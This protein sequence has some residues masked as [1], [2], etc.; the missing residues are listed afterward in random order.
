MLLK[1]LLFGVSLLAGS[2]TQARERTLSLVGVYSQS[3][4]TF[5][6]D[7]NSPY[8]YGEDSLA[9]ASINYG[10]L[11]ETPMQGKWGFETGLIFLQRGYQFPVSPGASTKNVSSWK[12]FYV[13]LVGRF[14]PTSVFTGSIGMYLDQAVGELGTYSTA[15]PDS[16]SYSTMKERGFRTFDWG[17]TYSA[18]VTFDFNSST[19]FLL[20][21]RFNESWSNLMDT[22]LSNVDKREKATIHEA[23][24]YLGLVI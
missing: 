2:L 5:E 24:L 1:K 20:E 22:S 14:H 11:V 16:I 21:V 8:Y 3:S 12:S 18:G 9:H 13:P 6:L 19:M 23:Q 15:T 10:V 7:T 4:V 17:M